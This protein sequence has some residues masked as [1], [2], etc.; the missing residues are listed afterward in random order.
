MK[1]HLKY[2][3]ENEKEN[4]RIVVPFMVGDAYIRP[5]LSTIRRKTAD[6]L[7]K[8]LNLKCIPAYKEYRS[9]IGSFLFVFESNLNKY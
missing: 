5:S 3:L 8:E 6:K 2:M 1:K 9:D 7:I 4:A